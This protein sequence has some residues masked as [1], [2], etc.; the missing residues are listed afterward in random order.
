[1]GCGCRKN[2]NNRIARSKRIE[3]QKF[4]DRLAMAS[5]RRKEILAK[6]QKKILAKRK[7]IEKKLKFCKI[8]PHSKSTKIEK[9]KRIKICH[10][11]NT[12]IQIIINKQ[13][14]KCPIGNF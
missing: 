1:M 4:L 2:K 12:S 10:K 8:C 5:E 6:G 14:F 13:D 11:N 7:L 3:K 9:R